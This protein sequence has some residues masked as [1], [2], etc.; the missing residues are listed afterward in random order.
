MNGREWTDR[1]LKLL[2]T[3]VDSA[4]AAKIGRSANAVRKKRQETAIASAYRRDWKPRELKLLGTMADAA[5]AEML[6][7]SRLCVFKKRRALGIAAFSPANTPKK[8]R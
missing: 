7:C 4:I 1:E 2:G 5:L 6:G 3:D 8:Y